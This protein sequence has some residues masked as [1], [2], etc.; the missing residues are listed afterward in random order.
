MVALGD[1]ICAGNTGTRFVTDVSVVFPKSDVW[2]FAILA[3]T[4]LLDG[5]AEPGKNPTPI[6]TATTNLE[7][8][9]AVFL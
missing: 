7:V 8:S 9:L 1:V 6:T 4:L 3:A 2:A 5:G